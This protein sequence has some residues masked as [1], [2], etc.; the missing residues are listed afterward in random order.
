MNFFTSDLHLGHR[1]I[2][3]YRPEF[4]S[5]EDHDRALLE[6]ISQLKKRDILFVLGDFIFP[7]PNYDK[8]IQAM[9][10][11]PGRIKVIMGN[12][13]SLDLYR[14]PPKFEIQLPLFVYKGNWVS[15]APIHPDELRD[16]TLNIHGH[17]H[18]TELPDQRYFNVNFDVRG[19]D[20]VPFEQILERT[21]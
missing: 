14:A 10:K 21:P 4:A 18:G 16:R 19:H 20:F 17:I 3:K 7:G 5:M 11:M 9:V 12:H 8:Y 13:D 2:V 1:S 6:K 15:H